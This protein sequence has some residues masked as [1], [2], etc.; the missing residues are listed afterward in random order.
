M[1]EVS[2]TTVVGSG[3]DM[4]GGSAFVPGDRRIRDYRQGEIAETARAVED[5][6]FDQ[7]LLV[8]E[9]NWPDTFLVGSEVLAA[10]TRLRTLVAHRPGF[11][12]PTLAA[13][14]LA[15]LDRYSGGRAALHVIAGS[16]DYGQRRDGD[17][18]PKAERYARAEEYL[19]LLKRE[20]TATE[21]FDYEGEHYRVRDAFSEIR[22]VQ[23]PHPTIFSGGS[24]AEALELAA[25]HTDVYATWGEPLADTAAQI[26][27]VRELA[28]AHG[29]E[30]GFMSS[31]RPI[32]GDTEEEAWRRADELRAA[33]EA[34]GRAKAK[35]TQQPENE[36][37]RRIVAFSERA[38]RHD[39]A[40]FLGIARATGSPVNHS[41]LVGTPETVAEA[42]ADYHELGVHHFLIMTYGTP[43]PEL[44]RELLPLA[45][46][47]I[48]ARASAPAGRN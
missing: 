35:R 11:H 4:S 38:D 7:A 16:T 40:L 36:G 39:R 13:R 6:G 28:A 33:A 41:A 37:S 48:A 46:E 29:R 21:P 20:L 22:P 42:L 34:D 18:L 23:T 3:L 12:A 43:A 5:A 14:S 17:F 24:S 44:G 2:F 32:L 8:Y 1:S 26:A 47:R 19:D 45:R 25:R 10:T 31:F 9:S 15:T 30:I 27:R